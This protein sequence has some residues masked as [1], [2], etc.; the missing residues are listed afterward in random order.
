MAHLI[1]FAVLIGLIVVI[2]YFDI[3][4]LISGDGF[5]R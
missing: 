1:G 2:S 5:L 3:V 4:R